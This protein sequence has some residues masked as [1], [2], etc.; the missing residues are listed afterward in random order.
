MNLMLYI[1]RELMLKV[2]LEI[3]QS[4]IQKNH[5]TEVDLHIILISKLSNILLNKS[6]IKH[7]YKF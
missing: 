3:G 6:T 4:E 2:N 7:N 1:L 5:T